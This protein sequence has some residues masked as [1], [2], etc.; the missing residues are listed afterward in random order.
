LSVILDRSVVIGY[1]DKNFS[2]MLL[3]AFKHKP[4]ACHA[5]LSNLNCLEEAV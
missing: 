5:Y 3:L 2:K 4:E 1:Y